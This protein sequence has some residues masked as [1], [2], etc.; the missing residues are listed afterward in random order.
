M[1]GSSGRSS[2]RSRGWKGDSH[3]KSKAKRVPGRWDSKD[4]NPEAEESMGY[5]RKR[6]KGST[7]GGRQAEVRSRRAPWSRVRSWEFT[8][9]SIE[10]RIKLAM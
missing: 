2:L 4:S 9:T 5:L 1:L 7:P 6:R 10:L 8:P 3:A